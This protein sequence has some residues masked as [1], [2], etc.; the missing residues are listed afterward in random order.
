MKSKFL[1]LSNP[2][3]EKWEEMTPTEK[4][5]YCALCAKNVIDFTKMSHS[6]ITEIMRKSN[7]NICGR[8]TKNQLNM[9]LFVG[10]PNSSQHFPYANIA[11]G[12]LIATSLIAAPTSQG[13]TIQLNTETVQTTNSEIKS[14]KK[15]NKAKPHEDRT[16]AV[17][18]FK[19]RVTVNQGEPV[20]NAEL[21]FVTVQKM[22]ITHTA[23][24]GTFSMEIPLNLIDDDN[25]LRVTYRDIVRP[26]SSDRYFYL[27]DE[28]YILSKND[29]DS[30]YK[31][32]AQTKRYILGMMGV[33]NRS[34]DPIVLEN[35]VELD[36]KEFMKAMYNEKS[37][38]S[39]DTKETHYFESE[40]AIAIYGEKA[41]Y[42]LIIITEEIED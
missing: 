42:G 31:I 29:M 20:E 17:K 25:V 36:Y 37:S 7:G 10:A 32:T 35:G 41:K 1:E 38:I 4:G 30:E 22:I 28:D 6:E 21:I 27:E 34:G 3:A 2:C 11:A 24:D 14:D 19:G 13:K 5:R 16:S 23:K 39:V 8:I 40:I 12:L 18:M 15:Q 9:P 33:E 26:D